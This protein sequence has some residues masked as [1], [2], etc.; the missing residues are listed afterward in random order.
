MTVPQLGLFNEDTFRKPDRDLWNNLKDASQR[1]VS[2]ALRRGCKQPV[3]GEGNIDR[4][5]VAFVGEAPGGQED[6]Q[7]HPFV[8][9]SGELLGR[10]IVAM[11][12]KREDLYLLNAVLCRPPDNR[13]PEPE[14]IAMCREWF[15]GQMRAVQP[16]TIVALG[17]TA[18][19]VLLGTKKE[20]LVGAMRK[21]WHDWQGIP[22]RVTYHP[23][24]LLRTPEE[25]NEAWGDL[26]EVLKLLKR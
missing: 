17:A 14:E 9:P 23:S 3:F 7:G 15:V 26:Q 22:V 20:A 2:C 24:F 18:G 8:G 19:N 6:L 25:K 12:F 16:K 21:E 13:K 1:C 10:M 5:A 4:P 11:G